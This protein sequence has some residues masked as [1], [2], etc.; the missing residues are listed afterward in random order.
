M[1]PARRPDTDLLVV[2][3]G[4][5]G[6]ALAHRAGAAGLSVRLVDPAPHRPWTQTVG[7]FTDDLP[8]WLDRS[9][10]AAADETIVVFTPHRRVVGRGYC[11]LDTAALQQALTLHTV[12]VVTAAAA[13]VSSSAVRLADGRL[14]TARTVID[15]RG[16]RAAAVP[17]QRAYGVRLHHDGPA[18]M[19]LMDWSRSP[20][21]APTFSYRVRLS[22]TAMLVEETSLAA[23]DGPAAAVLAL[24]NRPHQIAAAGDAGV[25]GDAGGEPELVDFPLHPAR[26]PWRVPAGGAL[27]FGA[28]GGQMHPASGYSI[29]ESLRSAELLAGALAAGAD[30]RRALWPPAARRTYL[31]RLL[32]LQVLLRLDGAELCRFFDAFFSLPVADQR[33]YLSTRDDPAGLARTMLAVFARAGMRLQSRI[34]ATSAVAAIR[35]AVT[36][37]AAAAGSRRWPC[38]RRA[39]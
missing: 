28:G 25:P 7:M 39:P 27:A 18:P 2:G 30:P 17:H 24:R 29:A 11:I 38:P 1:S 33:A 3:A 12:S 23:C 19:V 20:A 22:P 26:L 21:A 35:L 13:W 9:V 10:I 36:A 15:A 16:N 8:S 32:G 34:A 5:A 14:L 31:L 4:P 37:T 6:R